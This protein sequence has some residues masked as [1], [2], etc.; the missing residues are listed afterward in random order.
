MKNI[1]FT[2]ALLCATTATAQTAIAPDK[3]RTII[4]EQAAAELKAGNM[5]GYTLWLVLIE[6]IQDKDIDRRLVEV[7]PITLK[8]HIEKHTKFEG[9]AKGI[10]AKDRAGK[11]FSTPKKPVNGGRKIIWP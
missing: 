11:F 10:L 5:D 1:L 9:A 8:M 4:L 3:A 6:R 2:L 7:F